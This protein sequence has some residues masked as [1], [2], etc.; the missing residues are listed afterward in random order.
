MACNLYQKLPKGKLYFGVDVDSWC[1][2]KTYE[3]V[4]ACKFVDVLSEDIKRIN[5]V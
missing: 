2:R 5:N 4:Q 3:N 1:R